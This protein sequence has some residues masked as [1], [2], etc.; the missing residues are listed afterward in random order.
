MTKEVKQQFTLRISRANSTELVVILYEMTLQ[1]LEEAAN[2]F[3]DGDFVGYKEAI[4]K[5][6]GCINELIQSLHLEY[7]PAPK[8]LRLYLYCIRR[9]AYAEVRKEPQVLDEIRMVLS[10]LQEAY[11]QIAPVNTSAP[12]M[13]NTQSVI[14]G[15][16]YGK[17]AAL[18]EDMTGQDSNRGM[19][20]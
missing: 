11:A 8:L 15:L 18:T 20:V 9:L 1:F 4:R 14:S 3:K 2:A 19:L 17:G 7:E 6:R 5:V 10:K 13:S 12:V 16:T